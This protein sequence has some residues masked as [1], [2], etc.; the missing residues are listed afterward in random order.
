VSRD[1][2]AAEWL[3]ATQSGGTGSDRPGGGR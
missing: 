2:G 3:N 1:E